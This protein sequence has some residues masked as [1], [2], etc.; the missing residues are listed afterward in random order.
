MDR[1]NTIRL[2][3]TGTIGQITVIAIIV[4]L[5]RKI[6]IAVDYTTI[7][8]MIAIGIGGMLQVKNWYISVILFVKAIL[9][10][11]FDIENSDILPRNK[12]YS[13]ILNPEGA[14]NDR[15]LGEKQLVSRKHI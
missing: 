3:L 14:P 5:S 7:I 4:F 8:G 1:K 6:G 13:E 12:F 11:G 15:E 2:Y 9:L 10:G